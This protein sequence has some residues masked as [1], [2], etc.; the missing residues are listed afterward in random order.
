MHADAFMRSVG[1]RR[2]PAAFITAAVL[3]VAA[4]LGRAAAI[5]LP[6]EGAQT[7]T[8][9][10]ELLVVAV[11][12]GV[13]LAASG[14]AVLFLRAASR[15]RLSES[16]SAEAMKALRQELEIAQSIVMAEP[17]ALIAFEADGTPRLVNHVLDAKLG[18]PLKLRNLMRFASWM[19]RGAALSLENRLKE[20]KASGRPV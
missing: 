10:S 11:V 13:I 7:A 19:E 5:T 16:R 3:G 1:W 8:T 6:A 15:V 14:A 4:A 9:V 12:S 2:R 18:V 17:Q 20:L